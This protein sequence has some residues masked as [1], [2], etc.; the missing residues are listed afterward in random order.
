MKTC[1]ITDLHPE[2]QKAIAAIRAM[3][4]EDAALEGEEVI[5]MTLVVDD[6][7]GEGV[8]RVTTEK[9]E[10]TGSNSS[11]WQKALLE[12]GKKLP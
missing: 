12:L 10:L 4:N 6:G 5:A 3:M 11:G 8:L 7:R 1:L 9:Q 2:D